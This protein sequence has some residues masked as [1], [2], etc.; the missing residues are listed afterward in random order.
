MHEEMPLAEEGSVTVEIS[1]L[2]LYTHHG[3]SEAERTVGQ[4][5]IFDI[6]FELEHCDS[7]VTDRIDDTVDYASVCDVVALVA[8]ERSYRTLERLSQVVADRL[9][10]RFTTARSVTVRVAKPEPP[11]PLPVEEVAV[12]L[13][14]ERPELGE[15]ESEEER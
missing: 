4:R 9:L 10:D 7:V 11:L 8:S 13:I 1:R 5:L 15:E 3:V 12:E 6:G 14:K 2:S